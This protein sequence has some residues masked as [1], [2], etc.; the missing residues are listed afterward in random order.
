MQFSRHQ[1]NNGV[2]AWLCVHFW[3]RKKK[4]GISSASRFFPASLAYVLMLL[5]GYKYQ[6]QCDKM[7]V[8]FQFCQQ[9]FS[10]FLASR[11]FRQSFFRFFS[12]KDIF[13]SLSMLDKG[14]KQKMVQEMSK[15]KLTQ[16]NAFEGAFTKPQSQ[17]LRKAWRMLASS[18]AR[19]VAANTWTSVWMRTVWMCACVR[20]CE[21][22]HAMRMLSLV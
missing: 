7:Q 5:L 19:C 17:F 11:N 21:C 20:V 6:S 2:Y 15:P 16:F 10:F 8:S 14:V 22:M 12:Q 1:Y 3:E 4:S 13:S 18:M 9:F